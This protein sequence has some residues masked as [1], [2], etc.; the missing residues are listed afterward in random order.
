MA[1]TSRPWSDEEDIA[2]DSS[3]ASDSEEDINLDM[4]T[5]ASSS[6]S[7]RGMRAILF[8]NKGWIGKKVKLQGEDY[9]K[10]EIMGRGQIF[11]QIM[12]GSAKS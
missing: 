5:T 9:Q 8:K 3:E 11:Y 6:S 2:T 12:W 10:S 7:T 1:Y 4:A